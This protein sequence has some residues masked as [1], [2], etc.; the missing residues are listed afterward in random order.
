M[1]LW[2][3][4]ILL[5]LLAGATTWLLRHFNPAGQAPPKTAS[6]HPDYYFEGATMTQ[7][8]ETGKLEY[9]LLS[10]RVTHHPDDDSTDLARP[11]F[12]Y[13]QTGQAPWHVTADHGLVPSGGDVIHLRGH[14]VV[15][16]RNTNAG[17]TLRAYTPKL[18][19]LT[20]KQK[21]LTDAPVRIVEGESHVNAIGMALD[22]QQNHMEL[23]SRVRGVYVHD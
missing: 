4:L 5:A 18:D 23:K 13:Y 6:H 3:T 1:K 16:H 17:E 21:A 15:T 14:V 22:M 8:D 10:S 20:D 12:T 19:V 9:R 7:L 11:R 2:L